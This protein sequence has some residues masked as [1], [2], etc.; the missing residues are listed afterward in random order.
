MV[1]K[2]GDKPRLGEPGLQ[3]LSEDDLAPILVTPK[4]QGSLGS[5]TGE[6]RSVRK[7]VDDEDEAP[8]TLC[9]P[10]P[11]EEEA[12]PDP[13]TVIIKKLARGESPAVRE[14]MEGTACFARLWYSDEDQSFCPETGC[15]LRKL[16]ETAYHKA[17]GSIEAEIEAESEMAKVNVE[18]VENVV[19]AVA[20]AEEANLEGDTL[21]K[22]NFQRGLKKQKKI[23]VK[24]IFAKSLKVRLMYED[25]GQPVDAYVKAFWEAL[26]S[27]PELPS[28]WA[29]QAVASLEQ[30]CFA[31]KWFSQRYGKGMMVS[32]RQSY[33]QFFYNGMHFG[34][35]WVNS[36]RAGWL[37][38]NLWLAQEL[39]EQG[40]T[41][42]AVATKDPKHSYK[43]YEYKVKIKSVDEAQAI[44]K[45]AL[46]VLK[47]MEVR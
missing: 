41:L 17:V 5:V 39:R 30:R 15:Q 22:V 6:V 7:L 47:R 40:Y 8:D 29:Y 21:N 18:E 32:R 23:K 42:A 35:F 28:D 38:C 19:E 37:D 31:A 2:S 16:C 14:A 43:F 20:R 4:M 46:S 24:K 3:G 44:A 36:A 1:K 33:W 12:K 26:H 13:F 25:K 27:P 34:R 45:V 10:A 11:A 9:G